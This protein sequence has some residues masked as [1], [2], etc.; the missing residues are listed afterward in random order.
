MS[1]SLKPEIVKVPDEVWR[2]FEEQIGGGPWFDI[3]NIGDVCHVCIFGEINFGPHYH[4]LGNKISDSKNI[5][6]TIRNCL[7]GD[8]IL[9]LNFFNAYQGR[10]QETKIY[11]RCY[12]AALTIALTGKKV[13]MHKDA[14]ILCHA[15]HSFCY[16]AASEMNINARQLALATKRIFDILKQKTEL[17]DEVLSGWLDG[18][19]VYFTAE[20]AKAFEIV[21]EIFLDPPAS[22]A[23]PLPASHETLMQSVPEII[24]TDDERWIFNLLRAAV[25]DGLIRVTSIPAFERELIGF[26]RTMTTEEK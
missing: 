2:H 10:V 12:S 25:A 7:G 9:A 13:L 5:H 11:G 24:Q 6:L 23:T 18:A 26:A 17:P 22:P 15:P 19:D 4:E 1:E 20:Q 14:G 8:S 3:R 16:A 21:D